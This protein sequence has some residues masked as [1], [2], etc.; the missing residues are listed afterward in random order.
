MSSFL[1]QDLKEKGAFGVRTPSQ[2]QSF[3]PK[4]NTEKSVVNKK[5][6]FMTGRR[7]KKKRTCMRLYDRKIILVSR[8]ETPVILS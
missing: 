6:L 8:Q 5:Y 3:N 7:K 2:H 4:Y 1:Q